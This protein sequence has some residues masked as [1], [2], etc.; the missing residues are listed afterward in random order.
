VIRGEPF[1]EYK[2][3]SQVEPIEYLC[4][5]ILKNN[6]NAVR[7]LGLNYHSHAKETNLSIPSYPVLF[8]KPRYAIADP[9]TPLVVPRVAQDPPTLDFECELVV[10]IGKRCKDV[11]E[12]QALDY[13]GGYTVGNDISHREW[14]LQRGG[15]QWNFGKGFDKM[16]PLG[17]GIIAKRALT[18]E[19]NPGKMIGAGKGLRLWTKV[20]GELVQEGWTGDMIF[21]VRKAIAFLSQGTTLFPGDLIFMGTPSGVGMSRKPP[22]WLKH[23]DLVEVGMECVGVCTN[24]IQFEDQAG[25][26]RAEG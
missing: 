11:T 16:T 22:R 24:Y 6:I 14:Q 23:G 12:H 10:V 15:G 19:Q 26:D 7:C 8:Y 1:G 4:A 2:L 21:G 5:P 25:K 13:V 18:L 20:N 17:P 3:T 9:K